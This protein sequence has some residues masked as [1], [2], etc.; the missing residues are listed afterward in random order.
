MLP[1]SLVLLAPVIGPT[2]VDKFSQMLSYCVRIVP[3]VKLGLLPFNG[4][5]SKLI[6][7]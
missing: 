5:F 7:T 1:K 6:G 2:K 3:K 4:L